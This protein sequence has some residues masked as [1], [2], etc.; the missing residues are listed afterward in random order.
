MSEEAKKSLK[1][2]CKNQKDLK[3][4]S[5][6]SQDSIV[7]L[8]DMIFLQKNRIFV[9]IVNRFNKKCQVNINFRIRR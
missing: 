7:V 8:K 4:I 2:I 9:M 6:Y 5:A 3:V 1:L